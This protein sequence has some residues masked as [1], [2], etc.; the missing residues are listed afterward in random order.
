MSAFNA[1]GGISAQDS[2]RKIQVHQRYVFARANQSTNHLI[3]RGAN[4]GLAGAHM[5]V[6]QKAHRKTNIV[7][8]DDHE[9]TGVD[10]VTVAAL[11]DTKR[12]LSLE[13]SMNVLTLVRAGLFM[14]MDKWNGLTAWLMIDPKLLGMN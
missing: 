9:L 10:V 3:D 13:S 8:I 1:K 4:G 14:L 5:R 6:L 2:P 7:G 12:V 11:L